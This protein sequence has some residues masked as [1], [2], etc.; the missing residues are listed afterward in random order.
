MNLN[1]KWVPMRWPC[2]PIEAARL[3]KSGGN[4]ELKKTI[5]GW[6]QPSSLQM[7]KGTPIN[8]L[9]VDWALGTS[10]DEAQQLAL[11]H[12]IANGRQLGLSFVGKVAANK[13]LT[14]MV[15]A[16]RAAGLEAFMLE[17][18]AK[19]SL[20]LPAILEFPR[21]SID[22]DLTTDIFSATGNV[23]PGVA[24]P[25]MRGDTGVGGP[26]GDPWVDS[27]GWFAL[28]ARQMVASKSLWL[29]IGLPKSSKALPV[30]NYCLAIADSRV[31]GS[32]W[33]ISLDD[34]MRTGMLNGDA[35]AMAAWKRI[36]ATLS[37]FDGHAAWEAYKPMGILAVVSDFRGQNAFMAGETLNLLNRRQVQFEI[38]DRRRAL[39][40]LVTGLK[41]ILWVDEDAPSAVQHR[42]LLAFVQQGGTVIAPKY[43]GPAG[44][45]PRRENWLFDYDIYDVSKGR[46]VRAAG[47]F[48]DP[49]QLARDTHLLVGRENDLA[50]LYN[51]GTTNCYTSINPDHRKQLVQIVNYASD[52]A[53]YVALWVS[54]KAKG[55]KLYVPNSQTPNPLGGV[56]ESD[57]TSFELPVLSVNCAVEIERVV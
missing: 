7:L 37:F 16:G 35:Q 1:P 9:V 39:T 15:A 11:K 28:L 27:N 32:R 53:S 18:P 21:D 23:W 52:A 19:Q 5:E 2:G 31:Y 36:N 34:A 42:N 54:M 14:A 43:W 12:L 46:I 3:S 50:R 25:T 49:Y 26:T 8:C 44:I 17:G 51:P 13:N 30:E 47:G 6:T 29:D 33:I 20:D 38:L 41:A 56:P 57:G 48:S 24:L 4:E 22:W 55:A 45:A 40:S 10:D